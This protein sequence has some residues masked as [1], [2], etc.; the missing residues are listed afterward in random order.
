MAELE[1]LSGGIIVAIVDFLM[2][3]LV[4]GGL[5]GMINLLKKF[6]GA[7][8][9]K[10]AQT[11]G[12]AVPAPVQTPAPAPVLDMKPRIAAIMSA[13]CEFTSLAPGSFKIDHIIP[14][15]GVPQ[16]ASS[17]PL[18]KAQIAAIAV[19]LH[20]FTSLPMGSLK[21]TGIKH[22]GSA[23]NWKMAGRMEQMK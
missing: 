18:N 16:A 6:V 9:E 15:D 12:Q 4:L 7:Y 8:E 14:L 5:S 22:L 23:S 3:F 21:I 10:T 1:G 11:R 13:L 20:E 2:V 17:S 19:A